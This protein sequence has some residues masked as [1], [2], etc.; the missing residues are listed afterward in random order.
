MLIVFYRTKDFIL[1]YSLIGD[2]RGLL[3]HAPV[4][5]LTATASTD[6]ISSI[7]KSL[8]MEDDYTLITAC[9]DRPNIKYFC[10][11]KEN[12]VTS[13]QWLMDGLIKNKKKYAKNNCLL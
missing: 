7:K 1:P 2:L 10:F 4:L 8:L 5:A 6:M 3:T 13:L 9:L 11:S 12:G